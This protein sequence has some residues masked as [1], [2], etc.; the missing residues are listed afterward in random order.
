MKALFVCREAGN[1]HTI[2]PK[3]DSFGNRDRLPSERPIQPAY[4]GWGVFFFV[5]VSDGQIS[6]TVHVLD[7]AALVAVFGQIG[8]GF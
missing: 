5:F 3:R 8:T 7:M 6:Q 2:P 1:T 4:V